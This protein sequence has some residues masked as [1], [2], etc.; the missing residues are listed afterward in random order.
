MIGLVR[1]AVFASMLMLGRPIFAEDSNSITLAEAKVIAEGAQSA[2]LTKDAQVSIVIVNREGRVV[3]AQ[4]MD[5][6]SFTSLDV[7]EGKAVAAATLGMPSAA[8]QNAIDGGM[9][10]LL[11]VKGLVAIAGGLPILRD[12]RVV[13]GIGVSGSS[14]TNDES[15][16]RAGLEAGTS[17]AE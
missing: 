11:T 14:P 17:L 3:L 4:R 1:L 16:A 9:L 12:E 5:E 6:T 2:A 15:F 7:A 10:S 13:G 8:I